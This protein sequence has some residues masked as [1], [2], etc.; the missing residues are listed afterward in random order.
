MAPSPTKTALPAAGGKPS[1]DYESESYF[2]LHWT[3][4]RY[5]LHGFF[6]HALYLLILRESHS[7]GSGGFPGL[8]WY[9]SGTRFEQDL[10]RSTLA[11]V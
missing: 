3:R 5:G 9:L 10:L 8:H 11:E 6:V 7:K 1:H 2:E 4:T